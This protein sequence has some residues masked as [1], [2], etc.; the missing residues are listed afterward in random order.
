M[1]IASLKLSLF[2]GFQ[3]RPL[4]GHLL[5]IPTRKAQALLAYC[6]LT[7][8]RPH[9][10]EKLAALLWGDTQEEHARNSLRQS[11]FVLR[12][13]LGRAL[14]HVLIAEGDTIAL[15]PPT[16]DV[17]VVTFERLIGIG[18]AQALEDAATLYTGDLLEGFVV[19][20]EPFEEW[21]LQERERLRERLMEVLA[22]LFRQ[23]CAMRKHETAIQTARRLVALDPMQES[24]HRALMRLY[25]RMGRRE[26]ALRQYEVCLA[27]LRRELQV[28]PEPETRQLYEL[29]L[30]R[31][32][33][34]TT[35]SLLQRLH[36]D[37]EL[38]FVHAQRECNRARELRQQLIES[39]DALRRRLL[40]TKQQVAALGR[41]P[42]LLLSQDAG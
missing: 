16:V 38:A 20:E 15:S 12:A 18:T 3:G 37:Q 33:A 32:V 10:R 21:L 30:R 26:A 1:T 22:R 39:R 34:A 28:D 13:A 6:A 36:A 24:V 27:V 25:H 40:D 11:L 2:G 9:Q 31:S 17:D 19:D 35:P 42:D 41:E 5:V 7:P 8:G 14:G 4:A 29:I 23:Q